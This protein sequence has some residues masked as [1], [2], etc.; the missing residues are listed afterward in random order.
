M[1][2]IAQALFMGLQ[3]C[4]PFWVVPWAEE[5]KVPHSQL[6]LVIVANSLMMG[7]VSPFAGMIFDR[8][9][10]HRVFAFGVC[11]CCLVY[12][13][14]SFATSLWVVLFLYGIILP[15]GVILTANLFSQIMVSRWFMTNRGVAMGISA[16]G[17]SLGAFVM[18]PIATTLLAHFDWRET[19]RILGAIAF[20][21]PIS[22]GM[23][24]LTHKPDVAVVT[25]TPTHQ[26]TGDLT[27]ANT[28]L[29]QTR[30]FWLIASGFCMLQFACLPLQF[31]VGSYAKDLGISQQQAAF[32]VSLS[33]V[34]LGCGKL[35]FGRL[36]DILPYR[37]SYWLA[38]VLIFLGI[39]IYSIADSLLPFTLGL[40]LMTLG[41]GCILPISGG[42]VITRFGIQAFSR[43]LGFLWL[44]IPLGSVSPYLAGLIREATGSYSSA[45]LIMGIPLLM[46]AVAIRRLRDDRTFTKHVPVHQV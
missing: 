25:H 29:L 45:Y 31:G 19:F 39:G 14:L 46:A 20:V 33:A 43:V 23:M 9:P 15:A 4:F 35:T 27:L 42:M 41:Q 32:A 38:T 6:M 36:A 30:D 3:F 1:T 12:T 16:L 5:F 2:I 10:A 28:M 44:F 40:M 8:Y 11:I 13:L 37:F 26:S 34:S 21:I 7:V 18:P 17:V 22:A 24:V